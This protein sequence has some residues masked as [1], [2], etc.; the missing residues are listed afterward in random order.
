METN[1]QTLKEIID[2]MNSTDWW[3]FGITIVSVVISGI[4]SYMLYRL[5]KNL[6]EQQNT[7]QQNN[8]RIQMHKEYFEI[9]DALVK[10]V[11][12]ID[13]LP[14]QF[15]KVLAGES[16]N[17]IAESCSQSIIARAKQLL[18]P[19][20]YAILSAFVNNYVYIHANTNNMYRYVSQCYEEP[21]IILKH[22]LREGGIE[23]FLRELFDIRDYL[24]IDDYLT[25]IKNIE[26]CKSSNFIEK[27]RSYS[28]LSDVIQNK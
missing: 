8:L 17:N 23:S 27:M 21:K 9:Y 11:N 7:I 20:D 10:D 1:P 15:G 22:K 19:N 3:M 12:Q 25:R 16:G 24:D 4:L 18:P 26:K 2:I 14:Y 13:R 28:D 6:G 5:T